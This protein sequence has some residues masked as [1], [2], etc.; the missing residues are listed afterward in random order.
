[1]FQIRM[2]FFIIKVSYIAYICA[3]K[4]I[5]KCQVSGDRSYSLKTY[6]ARKYHKF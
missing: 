5:D 2:N 6:V 3:M 1:M 4:D